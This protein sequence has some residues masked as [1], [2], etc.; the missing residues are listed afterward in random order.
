[1]RIGIFVVTPGR[2]GGGPET[3]E[4]QLLRALAKLDQTNEYIVYATHAE[5]ISAIG[6]KQPNFRYRILRPNARWISIPVSLPAMLVKDG[7]DFFHATMVPPP[8]SPKP[9]ILTILCSSNWKHPEFYDPKVVWRLNKLLARGMKSASLFLCISHK[10]LE[11]VHHDY[12]LEKDRL[13]VSYMGVGPEFHPHN[14][15]DTRSLLHDKHGIDYPYVLF[16]GQQQ[17][18]KNVFRVIEAYGRFQ[19]ATNSP[20]RLL[21]VG[22]EAQETGPIFDA[23]V[24][25]GLLEKV[26][27]LRYFP[28]SEL[29]HLYRGANMLVFPSLWE[30]FGLPVIEAMA[31]GTPVVTSTA[32]CLPEI[33]GDAAIVVDPESVEQIAAGMIQIETRREVRDTLIRKGLDRAKIFSWENCARSTLNAY[34]RMSTHPKEARVGRNDNT[35]GIRRG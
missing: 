28:F 19:Q 17:E 9:Y 33:A 7:V 14:P 21:L 18:R 30:G 25:F 27:R 13:D 12:G 22:R 34:A 15:K 16:V 2:Q 4:I 24:E 6:V 32:T 20:A 26:V 29:P 8:L 11:E 31:C 5:A 23:I 35:R 3:Y 10:L 1:M